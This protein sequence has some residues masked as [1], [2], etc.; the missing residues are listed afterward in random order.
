MLSVRGGLLMYDPYFV[1][2]TEVVLRTCMNH[3]R[4]SGTMSFAP[5]NHRKGSQAFNLE[6]QVYEVAQHDVLVA[7]DIVKKFGRGK[8]VRIL[9][10]FSME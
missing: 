1:R 2:T 5:I 8:S 3:C 4:C 7:C 9:K 10:G 6:P